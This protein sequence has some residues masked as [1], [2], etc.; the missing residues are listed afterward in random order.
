MG[1]ILV[2]LAIGVLALAILP[3]LPGRSADGVCP[4]PAPT[5]TAMN[6]GP[7][8][9]TSPLATP[10]LMV[11]HRLWFPIISSER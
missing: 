9:E 11:D 6:G 10:V 1:K 7:Y 4:T 5:T 8:H 2:I 3:P